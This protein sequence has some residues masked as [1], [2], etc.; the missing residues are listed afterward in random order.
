M[1]GLAESFLVGTN[2][3]IVESLVREESNLERFSFFLFLLPKIVAL[4]RKIIH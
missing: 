2:R 3:K 4:A 1:K